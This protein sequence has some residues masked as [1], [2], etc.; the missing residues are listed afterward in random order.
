MS[1]FVSFGN[2]NL[3]FHRMCDDIISNIHRLPKPILIQAGCN[4]S[5][6][7]SYDLDVELF[8]YCSY[9]QYEANMH[10]AKVVAIH[11]GVGAISSA[12]NNGK[13]PAVFPRE[14][15]YREHV[16]NHQIE[17]LE[18]ITKYTNLFVVNKHNLFEDFLE[19]EFFNKPTKKTKDIFENIPLNLSVQEYILQT[20]NSYK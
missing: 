12:L 19:A 18:E 17:L 20:I 8:E 13:V 11:A 14:A 5:Y 2:L 3:P 6:I 10:A 16:D 1:T 4:F 7:K 15:E 9:K